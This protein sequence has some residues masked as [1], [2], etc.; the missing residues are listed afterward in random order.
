VGEQ[1]SRKA[2]RKGIVELGS[3]GNS[4]VGRMRRARR[5]SIS[6]RR[7]H[8][9]VDIARTKTDDSGRH[10]CAYFFNSHSPTGSD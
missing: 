9:F 4:M 3:R 7:E 5:Q 1:L 8:R 6:C 2:I 10:G